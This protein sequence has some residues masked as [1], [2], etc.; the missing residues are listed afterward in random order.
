MKKGRY[1]CRVG[2]VL[3]ERERDALEREFLRR[4]RWLPG[5]TLVAPIRELADRY[6]CP[7][8]FNLEKGRHYCTSTCYLK[9]F[10]PRSAQQAGRHC[11]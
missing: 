6:D 4:Q 9:N 2:P 10:L 11:G 3:S 8:R 1:H 5:G 7:H